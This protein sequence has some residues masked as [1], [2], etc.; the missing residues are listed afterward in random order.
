[1]ENEI[2]IYYRAFGDLQANCYFLINK[3]NGQCVL[4][5]TGAEAYAVK[6][7][8]KQKNLKPVAVLLTHG[9]FDH[10]G[11]AEEISK[12]YNIKIYAGEEELKLL[13]IPAQN[14]SAHFGESFS[15]SGAEP[16][17]DGEVLE[18]AGMKIRVI[19]TPGHTRGGV[20][21][22]L[23]GQ[24]AVITGDTLFRGSFGRTDFPTG[25]LKQL[26]ESV[27]SKLFTLPEDTV[28]YC[29]H[30]SETTIGYEL[31]NNPIARH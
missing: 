6:E 29:G 20:C 10:I 5:D 27:K 14:L 4:V 1:M 31:E 28:C 7:I 9:H 8:I 15:L 11:A 25:N 12:T 13:S 26:L 23:L 30:G 19:A 18:M 2:L 22:Y 3:S 24:N 21:F 16:L 17:K